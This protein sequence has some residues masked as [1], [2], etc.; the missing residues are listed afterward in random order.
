MQH[1]LMQSFRLVPLIS[2][3]FGQWQHSG[4]T[5]IWQLLQKCCY[6]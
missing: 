1:L 4:T 5:D 6:A 2:V 3:K